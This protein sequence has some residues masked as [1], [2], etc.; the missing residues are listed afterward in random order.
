MDRK[1]WQAGYK[2]DREGTPPPTPLGTA[3]QFAAEERVRVEYAQSQAVLIKFLSVGLDLAFT[4]LR[5]AE[6]EDQSDPDHSR[7]ALV[8]VRTALDTIRRFEG[9]VEDARASR[10]IRGRANELE[11]ALNAFSW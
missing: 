5:T 6:M 7:S 3:A 4:M 10:D 8:Q 1:A 2:A 11:A 9:G